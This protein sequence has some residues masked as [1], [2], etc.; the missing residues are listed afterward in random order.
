[1]EITGISSTPPHIQ[2]DNQI[3][4]PVEQ[5]VEQVERSD[6]PASEE[7]RADVGQQIDVTA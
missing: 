2:S 5:R 6:T 7:N 3:P 1:M 4:E